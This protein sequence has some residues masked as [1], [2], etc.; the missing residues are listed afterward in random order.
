MIA[1]AACFALLA[2]QATLVLAD[3]HVN[4]QQQRMKDC[5][6]HAGDQHLSGDARKDFMSHCLKGEA[7]PP[8]PMT[9]QQRMK[10]CNA[11]AG[12]QSLKGDARKHFMSE[13]L[14]KH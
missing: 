13:C 3:P 12:A 11:R 1:A 5:N 2:G 7:V 4:S 14:K 6:A 9:P 8:P 10:D